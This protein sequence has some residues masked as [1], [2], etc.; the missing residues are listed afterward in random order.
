MEAQ[1]E[2]PAPRERA[3]RRKFAADLLRILGIAAFFIAAA[4]L[5]HFEPV[6]TRLTDVRH[7]RNELQMDYS[8]AGRVKSWAIFIGAGA[9]LVAIGVPRLWVSAA[10]GAIY[11]AALGTALALAASMG[12]AVIDYQLG[13][14]LLGGVARRRL[15]GR[16][17]V[18]AGR[19]RENGFWWTLYG[20][21]FPL[22]NST[23]MNLLCGTCRVQFRHYLGATLIGFFPLTVVFA[24]FGSGGAKGNY[25]QVLVGCALMFVTFL[26]QRQMRRFRPHSGSCEQN[27]PESEQDG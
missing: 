10:G 22:A 16:V 21:L 18:W 9:A 14:S 6:R 3:S 2:N 4:W 1:K 5:L 19:L 24:M 20:R 15:G 7:L 12:G 8:V 17:Q 11:G 26:V 23:L 13:K 27:V 25:S